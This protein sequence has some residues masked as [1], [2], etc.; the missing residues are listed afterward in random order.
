MQREGR[1]SGG[2]KEEPGSQMQRQG[3]EGVSEGSIPGA[4][5]TGEEVEKKA[6]PSTKYAI[7]C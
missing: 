6:A 7:R 5:L 4:G 2:R 3:K 1:E